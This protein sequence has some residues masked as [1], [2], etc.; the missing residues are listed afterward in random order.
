MERQTLVSIRFAVADSITL[1]R[2]V[3]ALMDEELRPQQKYAQGWQDSKASKK[4]LLNNTEDHNCFRADCKICY[5]K[6]VE[7]ASY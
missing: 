3:C 4:E 5:K 1:L 7:N 6:D 2:K